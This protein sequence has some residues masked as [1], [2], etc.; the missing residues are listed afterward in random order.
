MVQSGS[1]ADGVCV[2][3]LLDYLERA[4]GLLHLRVSS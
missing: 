3:L 4:I 2:F 1:V